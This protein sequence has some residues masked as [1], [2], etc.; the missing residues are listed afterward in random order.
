M[1]SFGQTCF[2]NPK[3]IAE[4]KSFTPNKSQDILHHFKLLELRLERKG[5]KLYYFN[6]WKTKL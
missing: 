1:G 2:K 6:V 4:N 5:G 3:S